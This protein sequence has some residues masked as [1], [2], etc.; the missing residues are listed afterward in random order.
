MNGRKAA[1]CSSSTV[2]QAPVDQSTQTVDELKPAMVC[3]KTN[4]TPKKHAQ[5]LPDHPI[6]IAI[7]KSGRIETES[8]GA[9]TSVALPFT[10]PLFRHFYR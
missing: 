8:H 1:M 7:L 4:L 10:S 6:Q 2:N 3:T 5:I 9:I